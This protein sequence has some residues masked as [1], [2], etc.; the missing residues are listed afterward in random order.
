MKRRA[1]LMLAMMMMTLVVASGVALAQTITCSTKSCEG[2]DQDDTMTNTYS[3][4]SS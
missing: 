3:T 2:T 1:I 4:Y